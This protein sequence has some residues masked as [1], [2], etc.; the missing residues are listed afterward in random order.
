MEIAFH[1]EILVSLC[2]RLFNL[3][4]KTYSIYMKFFEKAIQTS[5]ILIVFHSRI[6]VGV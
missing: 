4:D 1:R 3:K 2:V 6:V 5:A